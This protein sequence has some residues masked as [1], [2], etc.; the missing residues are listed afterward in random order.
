MGILLNPSK[1]TFSG[2]WLLDKVALEQLD[3][4]VEYANQELEKCRNEIIDSEAQK[5]FDQKKFDSLEKAKTFALKHSWDTVRKDIVLIS[6]DESKLKDNSIKELLVDPKIK[7]VSPKELS[8]DIEYGRKNRFSFNAKQRYDGELE[9]DIQSTKSEIEDELNYKLE[10]WVDKYKPNIIQS[11]WL[12]LSFPLAIF[13]GFIFFL[14]AINIYSTYKPS[15]QEIYKNQ[16]DNLIASGINK[17]NTTEAIDILLKINS[18]Y[19][20]EDVKEEVKISET[21][22]RV[23]IIALSF[24]LMGIFKPKT[25]IGVGKDKNKLKFYKRYLKFILFIIPGIFVYPYIIE[26]FKNFW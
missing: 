18:G 21:A 22:K 11:K 8:I 17:E 6:N 15:S 10:N 25:I 9:Y 24:C 2:P 19:I 16:I 14:F 4:I 7:N 3:E 12:Q 23:S 5:D 13:S 20:P 26:L 1:R